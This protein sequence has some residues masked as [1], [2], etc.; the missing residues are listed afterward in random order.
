MNNY[1]NDALIEATYLFCFKRVSDSEAAKDLSQDILLDA[2]RAIHKDMHFVSFYSWYWRMAR[3]KYADYVSHKH[4]PNLPIET[5]VGMAA[6]FIQPVDRFI[7]EE[8]ISFLRFSLSRLAAIYREIVIRYYLKEH[9]IAQIAHD[10]EIPEGTVKS[11]LFDAKQNLKERITDM[12]HIGTS[13]YAPFEVNWFWGGSRGAAEPIMNQKIAQQA[14]VFCRKE[15]KTI[16]E[17]ADEIGVAPVYLEP[18]LQDMVRVKLLTQPARNKFLTN[19]CVFPVQPYIN[20]DH[21]AYSSFVDNQFPKKVSSALSAVKEEILSLDFYGNDFDYNYLMWIWYVVAGSLFGSEARNLYLKRYQEKYPNEAERQYR[22]TAQFTCP[23]ETPDTSM[24]AEKNWVGWSNLHNFFETTQFGRCEYI[25]DFDYAP[26]PSTFEL[27]GGRSLWIDGSNI[28]LLLEL[29]K[30]PAK[31]LNPY[32]EEKVAELLKNGLLVRTNYGLRVTLPIMNRNTANAIIEIIRTAVSPIAEEYE[33][34][35]T[36]K[37]EKIILPYVR[38]DLMSN[39]IHWDMQMF[40]Q[41]TRILFYY[42][43][44]E[45]EYLS[46]PENF[47]TSAA[48]LWIITES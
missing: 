35:V 17:I 38:R 30:N 34:F 16:N 32:E 21:A 47:H 15:G 36:E 45:S 29:S 43:L 39:F 18:I 26:F 22:I 5:A 13:S 10:L 46:R 19:F 1:I 25:N 28:T 2:L 31:T 27:E 3:N 9:S 14:A 42:G 48:A 41:P 40:L 11:R 24:Y 4:N 33:K 37:I 6:D 8:E 20:A 23:D 44:Y 12:N 7:E